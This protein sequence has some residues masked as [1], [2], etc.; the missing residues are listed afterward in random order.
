[1]A[2]FVL[3]VVDRHRGMLTSNSSDDAQSFE[4]LFEVLCGPHAGVRGSYRELV[5]MLH[6]T[7]VVLSGQVALCHETGAI[8]DWH[9]QEEFGEW[10][11]RHTRFLEHTVG[12]GSF[13]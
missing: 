13:F 11:Q 6:D 5:Q 8:L 2:T 10:V 4:F 3:H 12:V 7:I 9:G 1:M